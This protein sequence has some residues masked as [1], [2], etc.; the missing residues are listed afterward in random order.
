MMQRAF[1]IVIAGSALL[2]LLPVVVPI[3]VLLRVTGERE[4]FYRQERVGFGGRR[5]RVY[6]FVTMRRDSPST[7]TGLITTRNDPR[8]LP[9]GRILRR[10]KLNELPQILNVLAGDMSIVGPR[11]QVPEHFDSYSEHVR[12]RIVE[13]K[14]GLTGIGSIVFRDEEAILSDS[15]LPL[16]DC[17][18]VV[19][20]PYKGELELWYLERRSHGLYWLLVFLTAY[21][22]VTRRSGLYRRV[23][24]GLPEPPEVLV[25]LS[26]R[27]V[28]S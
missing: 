7:G 26:L 1:D 13:V 10:T 23:L 24:P 6:K 3:A 2:L 11:P 20:A 19:I 14:P 9:L 21:A 28:G 5:F 27:R 12:R 16:E 22:L 18:R 4:I 8:V 17:Y 25:P 15:G